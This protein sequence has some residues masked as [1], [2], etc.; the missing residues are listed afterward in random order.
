MKEG[1][2]RRKKKKKK[3]KASLED[4]SLTLFNYSIKC[5]LRSDT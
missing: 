5:T 3:E 4:N 2:R 1:G